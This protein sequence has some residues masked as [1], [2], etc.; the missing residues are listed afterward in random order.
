MNKQTHSLVDDFQKFFD[1][2]FVASKE[3]RDEALSI[4]YRV[5]CEEFGYESKGQFPDKKE[6]DEYD[7]QSLHCL[8]KHKSSNLAAGCVR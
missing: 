3:Q 8:I 6:S 5:Y 4:R 7:Q 1:V 2:E